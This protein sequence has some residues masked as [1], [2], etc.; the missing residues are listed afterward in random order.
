MA[1]KIN[2]NDEYI[3]EPDG[4]ASVKDVGRLK[5][6]LMQKTPEFYELEPAEVIRFV[7]M[8]MMKII[9]IYKMK[10]NQIGQN[11]VQSRQE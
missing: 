11:M 3:V 7:L 1:Y 10:I 9:H 5:R 8:K 2:R 4:V 6:E